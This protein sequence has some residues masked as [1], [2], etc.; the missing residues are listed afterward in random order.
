[1]PKKRIKEI[2]NLAGL[3]SPHSIEAEQA[4]IAS[5]ILDKDVALNLIDKLREE[6][7]Y[8]RPHGIIFQT[9]RSLIETNQKCD[10]VTVINKLKSEDVLKNIG[11]IDYL[12]SILD[13]FPTSAYAEEY[14]N[15][16][17]EK[18][19]LRSLISAA[20]KIIENSHNHTG[21][22]ENIIDSA[23]SI[24]FEIGKNLSEGQA[25]SMKQL[26]KENL[27][28]FEKIHDHHG[29][30]TGIP[31]GFPDLDNLTSGFQKSDLTI[32][33]SRP[34][35]GKTALA[36]NIAQNMAIDQKIPVAIFSLE[37]SKEQI[38]QRMLCSEGKINLLNMRKGFLSD[39]EM[40]KLIQSAGILENASIF[41]DDTA[42]LSI[43]DLRAKARRLK[44]K[45]NI[46][47]I[48]V[49]YLQ[50]MRSRRGYDNRQQEI[51]EISA[52]LKGLAKELSIPVIALSQ[53]S[54]YAERR[55]DKKPQLADLRESGAIEQDADIVILIYREEFY[56]PNDQNRGRA[57]I[58][59]AKQRNGPTDTITFSFLKECIRFEN[60][61]QRVP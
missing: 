3:V 52:G 53:L 22:I 23:E 31:S 14:F 42:G 46:Q 54:R 38:V 25:Y 50:L 34:S 20:T 28:L 58:I 24:I 51:S 15:I 45:E 13:I 12:M 41:I 27:E 43:M 10:L 55:D 17:R 60:F 47:L 9:I 19:I 29:L 18:Y 4:L 21:D 2:E 6:Y 36:C 33:A 8:D 48:I 61:S 40:G 44:A 30:V 59:I 7:F 37:M 1:M 11:G 26:V 39:K 57:D 35:M 5:L 32:I 56:Q 16:V 49:D